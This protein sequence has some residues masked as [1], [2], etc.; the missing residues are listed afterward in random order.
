[1]SWAIAS[2]ACGGCTPTSLVCVTGRL[3]L[4]PGAVTGKPRLTTVLGSVA[5]M[6][7]LGSLEDVGSIWM[8][9]E[10]HRVDN[11]HPHVGQGAYRHT[12]ALALAA[13]APIIPRPP[14]FLEGGLPG[15]LIQHIAQRLDTGIAPMRLGVVA[16]RIGHRRGAC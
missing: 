10:P 11:A 6:R 4:A 15:E 2:S 14:R 1:M 5:R 12:V 3:G 7:G 16:T 8:L 9:P 13:L